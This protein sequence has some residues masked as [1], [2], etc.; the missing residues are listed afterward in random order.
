M[1]TD[2]AA[3]LVVGLGLLASGCSFAL[4]FGPDV[5]LAPLDAG[6]P[7]IAVTLDADSDAGTDAESDAGDCTAGSCRTDCRAP[8]VACGTRCVDLQDDNRHCGACGVTC[9]PGMNHCCR[10]VCAERCQ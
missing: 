6:A 4:D 9:G 8:E 5:L 3:R 10:G 7:D 1:K 2:H